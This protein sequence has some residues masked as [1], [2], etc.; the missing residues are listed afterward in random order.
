MAIPAEVIQIIEVLGVKGVRRVRCKILEGE[1]KD[2]ILIRN[3][4]GPIRK[5]DIIMIKEVEMEFAESIGERR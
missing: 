3:V 2:R 1:E 5:G 4:V